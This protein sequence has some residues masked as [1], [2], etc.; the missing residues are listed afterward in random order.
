MPI[1]LSRS[2][3]RMPAFGS[4]L[5]IQRLLIVRSAVRPSGRMAKLVQ[6]CQTQPMKTLY[7]FHARRELRALNTA[8]IHW[9][10]YP[11]ISA[12]SALPEDEKR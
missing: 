7:E 5:S 1:N 12:A 10:T 2:R 3:R 6:S 8:R 11:E 9:Q 4:S